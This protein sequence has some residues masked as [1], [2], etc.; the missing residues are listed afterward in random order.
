MEHSPPTRDLEGRKVSGNGPSPESQLPLPLTPLQ[1]QPISTSII[2]TGLFHHNFISSLAPERWIGRR[3]DWRFWV[4]LVNL[5]PLY[6]APM[7]SLLLEGGDCDH[8]SLSLPPPLGTGEGQQESM[9]KGE[10]PNLRT[11]RA[12]SPPLSQR[13]LFVAWL[14]G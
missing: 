13:R 2:C 11:P 3:G 7:K 8:H 12:P 10:L 14:A 9:G 5:L 1:P 6:E 4:G